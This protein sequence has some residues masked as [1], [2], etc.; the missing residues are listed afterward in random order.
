MTIKS[1]HVKPFL[2]VIW[3]R[4]S[5]RPIRAPYMVIVTLDAITCIIISNAYLTVALLE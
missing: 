4:C 1:K 2:T 5:A 3:F